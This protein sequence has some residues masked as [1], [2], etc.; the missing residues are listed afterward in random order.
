MLRKQGSEHGAEEDIGIEE[1]TCH[2]RM[3]KVV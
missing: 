3:D 1:G 2:R